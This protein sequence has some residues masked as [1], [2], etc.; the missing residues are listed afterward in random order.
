MSLKLPLA[1]V[2]VII[3][4]DIMI[5]IIAITIVVTVV[6][7]ILILVMVMGFAIMAI[8]VIR[9]QHLSKSDPEHVQQDECFVSIHETCHRKFR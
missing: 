7:V 3:I 8:L 1:V 5:V 6:L 9:N 4:N 2:D